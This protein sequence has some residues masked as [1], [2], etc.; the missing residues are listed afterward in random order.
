MPKPRKPENQGLPA[1]WR[2]AHGAYYYQVPIGLEARWSGK[3]MF[4]LGKTLPEAY[5]AW[6][7]RLTDNTN[8]NIR[9]VADL[10]DRYL[11]EVVPTKAAATRPLNALWIKKLRE[12]FGKLALTDIKP[13]LVY[14]YVD[15]RSQKKQNQNGRVTGG[16]TAAHREIEVLSHA[17]TKAVEWGILDRHP[18]KGEVRLKGERPRD[19]Y[20]EDWEVIEMLQLSSKREKGSVRMIQAY[21]RLKLMTGMARGD[22]LRLTMSDIGEDG[23]HIQRHKTQNSSGKRTI[24]TWTP[25]LRSTVEMAI[26]VRTVISPFLFSNRK[27]EGYI[28]EETGECHGWDSMWQRFVDRILKETKVELRLTEHDIR[29]KCA[30]DADSL[31]HARALLSHADARTTQEIYRRKPELVQPLPAFKGK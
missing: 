2:L 29:A 26:A 17:F 15:K 18:F 6:A 13:S 8:A 12:V 3:K 21:V 5:R 28:N 11:L 24:Y 20:L 31:D 19:R 4:R 25:E 30:S 7:E 14:Q 16:V 27:C 10:L 9:S 22:M 1:R 23:I